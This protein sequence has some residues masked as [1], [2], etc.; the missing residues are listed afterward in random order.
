MISFI[1]GLFITPVEKLVDGQVNDSSGSRNMFG[2]N[3]PSPPPLMAPPSISAS[4]SSNTSNK[5]EYD[6]LQQDPEFVKK[7]MNY[8]KNI[9]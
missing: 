4:A 7:S 8:P 3:P 1:K 6:L 5:I 9:M 2:F